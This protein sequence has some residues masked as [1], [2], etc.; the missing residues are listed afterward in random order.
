M[1]NAITALIADL[2]APT[3]NLP[4]SFNTNGDKLAQAAADY[5]G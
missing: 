1:T 2:Q 3:E 5:C 4:P